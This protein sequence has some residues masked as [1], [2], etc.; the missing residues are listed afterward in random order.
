MNRYSVV[1]HALCTILQSC[2]R[3]HSLINILLDVCLSFNLVYDAQRLLSIVLSQA[4]TPSDPG[5]LPPIT[6]PAHATYLVDLHAR[7]TNGSQSQNA[8]HD[9]SLFTTSVFCQV[10]FSALSYSGDHTLFAWNEVIKLGRTV[11]HQ[12]INLFARLIDALATFLFADESGIPQSRDD[13]PIAGGTRL[14]TLQT[15][16]REW[17]IHLWDNLLPSWE[18]PN[19]LS[20]ETLPLLIDILEKCYNAGS[21]DNT[22]AAGY[23]YPRLPDIATVLATQILACSSEAFNDRLV[24]VLKRASPIPA[25]YSK[26]VEYL[27]RP[28]PS[29]ECIFGE[30]LMSQLGWY[31]SIL[32]SQNLLKLDASLWACVLSHFEK[33]FVNPQGSSAFISRLVDAVD[34]AE[35]RCFGQTAN[36]SSPPITLPS[37]FKR[38]NSGHRRKSSGH[39]EWEEMV[40]CWIRK[41]PV[42]ETRRLSKDDDNQPTLRSIRENGRVRNV[43]RFESR[44]QCVEISRR[45]FG[46][47][48]YESFD[49]NMQPSDSG[50]E[51][52]S[53]K[54]NLEYSPSRRQPPTKKPRI[55][56]STLLADAQ[57]NRVDL[58]SNNGSSKPKTYIVPRTTTH[59]PSPPAA[60]TTCRFVLSPKSLDYPKSLLSDDSLDLFA[61]SSSIG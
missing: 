19:F 4:F 15:Q 49:S 22:S 38:G 28:R 18:S 33:T 8:H 24:S 32:R 13:G 7:W 57:T 56:F 46:S 31:S 12:D 40:E 21:V 16:L 20:S 50:S 27:C 55:N 25:T 51:Y 58:H 3:Y 11:G 54:E 26:L 48:T 44:P 1:S 5:S 53:D 47:A 42:H 37:R 30:H 36:D 2:S 45:F 9:P 39:W 52:Q 6:H 34:A 10:V 35:K 59:C 29:E 23:T 60:Q 61:A 14:W 43:V 17:M 41:T